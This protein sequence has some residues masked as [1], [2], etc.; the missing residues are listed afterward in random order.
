MCSPKNRIS[1]FVD[2]IGF[3]VSAAVAALI[4][5]F[6]TPYWYRSDPFRPPIFVLP[7]NTLPFDSLGLW[8]LCY[9]SGYPNSDIYRRYDTECRSFFT[10]FRNQ[11]NYPPFFMATQA[12]YTIGLAVC[13]IGFI[14]LIVTLFAGATRRF[15]YALGTIFLIGALIIAGSLIIFGATEYV[16]WSNRDTEWIFGINAYSDNELYW[17]FW[18]AVAADGLVFICAVFYFI[19]ARRVEKLTPVRK[20]ITITTVYYPSGE[21]FIPYTAV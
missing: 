4:V 5:S 9:R 12:L 10:F 7:Y 15:L 3:L 19:E 2:L 6:A 11:I 16:L 17:S 20:P 13:F 8:M 18:L 1:V 21:D 14:I